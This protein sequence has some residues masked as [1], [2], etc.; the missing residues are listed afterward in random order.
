M[1]QNNKILVIDDSDL[2]QKLV[3]VRIKE[4]GMEILTANDGP[5]GIETARLE[6][7]DLI[8]LDVDMPEMTG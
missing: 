2:I 7:P 8:L 5:T 4:P 3:E 1:A 6:S